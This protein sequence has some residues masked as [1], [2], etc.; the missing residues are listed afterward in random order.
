MNDDEIERKLANQD[1]TKDL[2]GS[3]GSSAGK[4]GGKEVQEREKVFAGGSGAG[5]EEAKGDEN[6]ISSE[7]SEDDRND[8]ETS[9]SDS[10]DG[11]SAEDAQNKDEDVEKLLGAGKVPEISVDLPL[12]FERQPDV[13]RE[14]CTNCNQIH[15]IYDKQC[16]VAHR[17]FEKI[18][19]KINE[20]QY[21]DFEVY[22][23]VPNINSVRWHYS[24]IL[25]GINVCK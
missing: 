4:E 2:L 17:L 20:Q 18:R 3:N 7:D 11:A 1:V 14:L 9:D 25:R 19:T 15:S 10:G 5:W 24:Y 6:G 16:E 8:D 21:C 12:E 23:L 22:L 13:D